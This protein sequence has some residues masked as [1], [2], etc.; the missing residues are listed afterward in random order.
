[1]VQGFCL[2]AGQFGIHQVLEGIDLPAEVQR[3]RC[4]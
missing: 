4:S 1:V 2:R 3:R